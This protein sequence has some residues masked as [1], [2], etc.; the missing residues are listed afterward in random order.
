MP[1]RFVPPR[2]GLYHGEM[3]NSAAVQAGSQAFDG[4]PL[5]F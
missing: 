4:I 3:Q 2:N 5:F 1:K